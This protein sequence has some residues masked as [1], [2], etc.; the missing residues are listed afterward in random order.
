VE[1]INAGI[2]T[3]G[4]GYNTKPKEHVLCAIKPIEWKAVRQWDIRRKSEDTIGIEA[5]A[6]R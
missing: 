5:G 4:M 1:S 3:T 6:E 2:V